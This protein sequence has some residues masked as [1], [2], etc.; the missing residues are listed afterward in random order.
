[1]KTTNIYILIDPLTGLVRYV[2]KANNISQRFK[3]HTNKA[4]HHNPHKMN[5]VNFLKKNNLKPIIE[6]IDIVPIKDWQFWETYWIS[7]FKTWG[8]DL[9]NYTSG[10]DGCSFANETTFKKGQVA[11]NDSN[12]NIKCYWCKKEFKISPSRLG[13]KKYCSKDCYA[14]SKKGIT[15]WNKGLTIKT[16]KNDNRVIG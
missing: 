10:G 14:K 9:L 16:K 11:H 2:G 5:W 6:V 8:Y 12:T 3:A 7:Q 15:P 4:R 13:I 1:M